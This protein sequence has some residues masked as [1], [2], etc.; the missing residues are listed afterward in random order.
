MVLSNHVRIALRRDSRRDVVWKRA[1]ATELHWIRR[2]I[3]VKTIHQKFFGKTNLT[4]QR[5]VKKTAIEASAASAAVYTPCLR[6]QVQ[7]ARCVQSPEQCLGV[8]RQ[9]SISCGRVKSSA[10][11]NPGL[12]TFPL[13]EFKFLMR[14]LEKTKVSLPQGLKHIKTVL[15]FTCD[16]MAGKDLRIFRDLK[17]KSR[18]QNETSAFRLHIDVKSFI[19]CLLAWMMKAI[20]GISGV[21]AIWLPKRAALDLASPASATK[22][23]HLAWFRFKFVSCLHMKNYTSYP[24]Y[25]FLKNIVYIYIFCTSFVHFLCVFIHVSSCFSLSRLVCRSARSTHRPKSSLDTRTSGKIPWPIWPRMHAASQH[26]TLRVFRMKLL[27]PETLIWNPFDRMKGH[28][29]TVGPF[30]S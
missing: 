1:T 3:L 27:N 14:S 8:S 30:F 9:D 23:W 4:K 7:I 6:K 11:A 2:Q 18:K 24:F 28:S 13:D 26:A 17:I 20:S 16:S 10:P 29:R 15:L 25:T 22:T 21:V 12:L 19:A 5:F